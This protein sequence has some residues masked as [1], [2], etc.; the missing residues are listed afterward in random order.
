[1]SGLSRQL[2][3]DLPA[4]M[5]AHTGHT[6]SVFLC[7]LNEQLLYS[8]YY[9]LGQLVYFAKFDIVVEMTVYG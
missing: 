4:C 2:L 1:M 7:R 9:Q 3:S 5:P 8:N 6:A